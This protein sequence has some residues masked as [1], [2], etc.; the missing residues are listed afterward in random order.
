MNYNFSNKINLLIKSTLVLGLFSLSACLDPIDLDI[1]EGFDNTLVVQGILVKGNPSTFELTVSRLFDFTPESVERVNVREVILTDESGNSFE[2]ERTGT[3]IYRT[4]FAPGNSDME[5]EIG[6]SYK[7]NL[8]TFDGR[9]YESILE[10]MPE[11]PK[12]DTITYEP[13][14][15]QLVFTNGVTTFQDSIIRFYVNTPLKAANAESNTSILWNLRRIF[16]VTDLPLGFDPS[17]TCYVTESVNVT[18]VRTFDGI[19]FN[20]NR[21]DQFAIHDQLL[22]GRLAEGMYF[23]VIQSALTTG[24]FD[25]WNQISQ[26]LDRD[27]N[28]FE[29]PAG[30]IVTN[31]FNTEDPDELVFGYFYATT[32]DTARVYIAPSVANFPTAICPPAPSDNPCPEPLCCNCLDAEISTTVR[33]DFWVE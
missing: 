21:L 25:Y 2:V 23:E 29:T 18:E 31:F 32:T 12:I 17:K 28:M 8:S 7:I 14:V 20:T 10:V 16:R 33:P 26:V 3:G 24:A 1:P 11:V 22:N 27:G 19:N 9:S 5:V 30:R 6:K 13:T 15:K 4:T